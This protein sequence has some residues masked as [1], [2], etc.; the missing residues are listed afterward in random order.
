MSLIEQLTSDVKDAMRAGETLR[1]DTLRMTLAAMKNRRIETGQDLDEYQQLAVLL[2]AVKS[3]TDS[4][5]QYEANDRQDLADQERAEIEVLQGYLPK[6]L[7]EEETAEIVRAKIGELGLTSK[8][9]MGQVMKAIMADHKGALDGKLVQRL[10]AQE[11][12]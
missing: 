6:Q 1:R 2:S 4:V 11:L 9:E 8:S 7:S 12:A 3:R 10:A 5:T